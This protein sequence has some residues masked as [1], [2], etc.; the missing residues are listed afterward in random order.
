MVRG[1][2]R[3][4]TPKVHGCQYAPE[5]LAPSSPAPELAGNRIGALAALG[6]FCQLLHV[7]LREPRKPLGDGK[8][9]VE[10]RRTLTAECC[11]VVIGED[12]LSILV[13]DR[14]RNEL[15]TDVPH[16]HPHVPATLLDDRRLELI[17]LG[18]GESPHV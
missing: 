17:P 13:N 2:S 1:H 8:E 16:V 15:R 9:A 5:A 14:Q 7:L 3:L 11:N 10:R 6:V 4:S 12:A 18:T